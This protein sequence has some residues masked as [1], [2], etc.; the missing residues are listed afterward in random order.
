[1]TARRNWAV[2]LRISTPTLAVSVAVLVAAEILKMAPIINAPAPSWSTTQWFNTPAPLDLP[3][4]RGKAVALYAFQMLCPGCVSHALPQA[5]RLREAFPEE[6]LAVIGLHSVFEHHAA[7]SP[8]TL[9]AFLH[10]YR[11]GFP[12]GIDAAGVDDPIP[13]TMS[14]YRMRGTPTLVLI[15]AQGRLRRQVFGHAP[16]LN[17]G[18]EITRILQETAPAE[19]CAAGACLAPTAY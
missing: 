19:D 6:A 12:V 9:E 13:Q 18:A 3:A 16:D 10:E 5:Q 1:M 8:E 4:L 11:I 15:D 17:V 14:A 7:N 2:P